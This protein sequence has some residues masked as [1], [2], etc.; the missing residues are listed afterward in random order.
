MEHGIKRLQLQR[1]WPLSR[2]QQNYLN[3]LESFA[4]D[5]LQIR[6]WSSVGRKTRNSEHF[7]FSIQEVLLTR[8]EIKKTLDLRKRYQ[9]SVKADIDKRNVRKLC[10]S[11]FSSTRSAQ[12]RYVL[13]RLVTN[14]NK[15]ESRCRSCKSA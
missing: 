6:S 13:H 11:E 15:S 10:N 14:P 9:T 1:L 2:W 3:S 7:C 5:W 8:V 4:A 12:Q